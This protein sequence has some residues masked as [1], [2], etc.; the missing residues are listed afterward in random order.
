MRFAFRPGVFG[1][2]A[3]SAIP[4]LA[5]E[6]LIVPPA[7]FGQTVVPIQNECSTDKPETT[8]VGRFRIDEQADTVFD[9]KTGLTWKRCA[10]GQAY[11]AGRCQGAAA[12]WKWNDAVTKFGVQGDG[13]RMPNV[14]ELSSIVENRCRSPSANLALFPDTPSSAFWSA[15]SSTSQLGSA[16]W[17]SF[18]VADIA[19]EG[20]KT[21]T[22]P[23]RLTRGKEWIDPSGGV[24]GKAQKAEQ[25][26]AEA[27]KKKA[28]R[29]APK[30][31]KESGG[32]R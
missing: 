7:E 26:R 14:D 1:V 9:T 15:S 11:A 19:N 25:Q 30:P 18:F 2:F 16:W 29:S 4:V 13:W 12:L 10:E 23:V 31:K 27:E 22:F 20:K 28:E 8:R 6:G 3:L 5:V 21:V 32:A 17:V 24:L